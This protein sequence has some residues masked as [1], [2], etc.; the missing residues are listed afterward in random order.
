MNEEE[1]YSDVWQYRIKQTFKDIQKKE[2]KSANI[3][4][5]LI[6][7]YLY[8]NAKDTTLMDI[9]NFFEDK[10]D[11]VK[12]IS[13]LDGRVFKSPTKSDMEDALLTAIFYY[14]KEINKKSWKEI[15]KGLDFK[16]SSIKYGIKIKNL[17][18]WIT[19]KFNEIIHSGDTNEQK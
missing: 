14:E 3:L 10:N 19:Q 11:F 9:Y 7:M 4:W 5:N 18:N 8:A 12:F 16:V 1:V 15:Q 6:S 2:D 17:N 13:L